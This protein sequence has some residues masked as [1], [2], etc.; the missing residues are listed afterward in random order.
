MPLFSVTCFWWVM[1]K[2]CIQGYMIK[3]RSTKHQEEKHP[4][5]IYLIISS[6]FTMHVKR[7]QSFVLLQSIVLYLLV[8][9]MY[10]KIPFFVLLPICFPFLLVFIFPHG[11]L[12]RVPKMFC[13]NVY[14]FS[15]RFNFQNSFFLI[16]ILPL[17]LSLSPSF[18]PWWPFRKTKKFS[19]LMQLIATSLLGFRM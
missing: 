4:S 14:I 17:S 8:Q 13:I 10:Y 15:G 19:F 2:F 6:A 1:M 3:I 18:H 12:K 16:S 11:W 9:Y 7:V 5:G